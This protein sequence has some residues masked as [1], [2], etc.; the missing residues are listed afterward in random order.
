M[1]ADIK[2]LLTILIKIQQ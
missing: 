1:A 2:H